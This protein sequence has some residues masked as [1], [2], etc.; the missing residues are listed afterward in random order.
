MIKAV[1]TDFSRV[2][3]F[4]VDHTYTGGLNTLNNDLLA[5][6]PDYEF[7][8]Y[9]RVNEELIAY[10]ASIDLPVYIFTSETI[11]EHPAI[12]EELDN[13]FDGVFSAKHLGI[14]KTDAEAYRTIARELGVPAS[15]IVYVDDNEENVAAAKIAGCAALLHNSSEQ[16][17][18]KISEKL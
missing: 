3:L 11:Q 6:N 14:R 9:F 1:V 16:T 5:E 12:R 17:I 13:V 15:E 18:K 10:F 7:K 4:P 2:L 8:K